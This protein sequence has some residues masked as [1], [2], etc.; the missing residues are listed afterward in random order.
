MLCR[1]EGWATEV[2][3]KRMKGIELVPPK[4]SEGRQEWRG[5]GGER[6]EMVSL[7]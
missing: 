3:S 4:A 6:E 1:G 5:L 7:V 2:K